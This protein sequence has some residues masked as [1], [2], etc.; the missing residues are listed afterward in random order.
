MTN[1]SPYRPLYIHPSIPPTYQKKPNATQ[2]GLAYKRVHSRA[3]QSV[4][5]EYKYKIP[6]A[7]AFASFSFHC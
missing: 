2:A 5:P 6:V 4:P 1:L 7:I 3:T